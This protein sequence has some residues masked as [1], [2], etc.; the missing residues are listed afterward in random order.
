VKRNAAFLLAARL[1]SAG[2]TLALLSYVGHTQGGAALGVLGVGLA[3]G[4]LLSAITDTGTASLLIREGAREPRD[5]GRLLVAMAIWR[6]V[7]LPIAAGALWFTIA[8]TI[9]TRPTAVF[10]VALGLA[11]QQFSELT[12]AVFVARQDMHVSSLHSAAEN[13]CWLLVTVGLLAGGASLEMAF[14]AGVLVFVASTAV[15]ISLIVIYH[16]P[17]LEIPALADLRRL[18]REL[19]PFAA[20]MVVGVAYSG[21]DT[22]LVGALVPVGALPVAGAYASAARLLAGLEY[23]PE[24]VSRASYPRLAT[25]FIAGHGQLLAE[26]RPSISFLIVV[27]LP[28]PFAMLVAGPWLMVALFGRDVAQFAWIVIPLS[29]V[30]P[31]RF[32]AYLFGMTLTSS[33][34]Q[35]RRVAA[36][37]VALGLVLVLDLLLIPRIGVAGAVVGSVAASIAV[38]A[39]YATQVTHH[40]A[41]IDVGP[42]V[43]RCFAVVVVAT[44]LGLALR[45]IVGPPLAALL[46]MAA[47]CAGLMIL[48]DIRLPRGRLRGI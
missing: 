40:A 14:G 30:L 6:V 18:F 32:L 3:M 37:L 25:A 39:V 44:L 2:T 43:A 46:M 47:Y 36:V 41:G 29:A 24:A 7:L 34:A 8:A 1:I 10:L 16:V 35:E 23:I 42:L 27:G 22:L 11:V 4:A 9:S 28:L 13:L 17:D 48:G 5:L 38:F 33:N 12:R 21:I 31:L 45:A 20:F 15:G 26:L 19:A